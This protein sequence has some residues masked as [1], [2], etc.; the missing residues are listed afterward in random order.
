M[1]HT[2]WDAVIRGWGAPRGRESSNPAERPVTD[3]QGWTQAID[4]NCRERVEDQRS[5][6]SGILPK[7]RELE[8]TASET[9]HVVKTKESA[10]QIY[11]DVGRQIMPSIGENVK[12]LELSYP[13]GGGGNCHSHFGRWQVAAKIEYTPRLR[14]SFSQT[15]VCTR[16]PRRGQGMLAKALA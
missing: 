11:L 2:R 8:Q 1:V 15:E 12:Q 5:R 3:L 10:H 14:L 6:F 9:E 13:A 4:Q 7:L 16:S